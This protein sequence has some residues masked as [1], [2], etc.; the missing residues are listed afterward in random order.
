MKLTT[1]T[2]LYKLL[3]ACFFN[4][5]MTSKEIYYIFS[6]FVK[7]D[8]SKYLNN[9][10]RNGYFTKSKDGDYKLTKKAL[11]KIKD[12]N[13]E[14]IKSNNSSEHYITHNLLL[15]KALFIYLLKSDLSNLK[16]I[17]KEKMKLVPLR[18]I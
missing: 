13:I 4:R 12:F 15:C 7:T 3:L 11:N 6:D 16:A 18:Q 9:A 8:K 14:I 2:T 10:V 17:K 1:E 5:P